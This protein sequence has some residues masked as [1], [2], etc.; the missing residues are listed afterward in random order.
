MG[1]FHGV[2]NGVIE[3]IE[4]FRLGL[5]FGAAEEGIGAGDE[6]GFESAG[7]IEFA[8]EQGL[9]Q[10]VVGLRIGGFGDDLF[11]KFGDGFV[12]F[13]AVEMLETFGRKRVLRGQDADESECPQPQS[14]RHPPHCRVIRWGRVPMGSCRAVIQ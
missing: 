1:V 9:G 13:E 5:H 6:F 3:T 2:R 8:V 14:E 10:V 12:V 11:L 4:V 7:A